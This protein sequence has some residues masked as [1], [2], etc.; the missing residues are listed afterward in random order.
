MKIISGT[1]HPQLAKDIANVMG[2]PLGD[3]TVN[4][5]PDGESF[6]QIKESIRGADA[7]I[8]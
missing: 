7:F 1:A 2:L 3:A 6:V 4:T 8:V 5:F